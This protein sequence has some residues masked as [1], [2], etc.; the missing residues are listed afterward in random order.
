VHDV[1]IRPMAA[2]DVAAAERVTAVGFHELD[3]RMAR[4]SWPEPEIRSPARSANWV[5]R[6]H[7]LLATDPGG[8]WVAERDGELLGVAVSFVREKMWLL[9]SYAVVP[10][11]QGLGL[12]RALLAPALEHGR[13]CLRGML[14]ASS[15]PKALRRYHDAG[16][17]LHPQMFLR[18]LPDRTQIPVVDHVREGAPHDVELLDSVDRQTR[19]AAHGVDHE[20]LMQQSRLV[21]SQTR[22]AQGY[23][24]VGNGTTLLAATDRRT[25]SRLLW[26]AIASADGEVMVGHVTAENG[27]AVDVGFAARLELHQEGFLALRGMKPP[28]PYLSHGAMM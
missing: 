20:I 18:G 2:H 22:S 1:L 5:A 7:H 12:G 28:K 8:S 6:T 16:F 19:G 15:D 23:A 27:W 21:V 4:R 17:V 24:Y 10:G 25:A 14:N 26:E 3:T 11:A 13:G 9:A